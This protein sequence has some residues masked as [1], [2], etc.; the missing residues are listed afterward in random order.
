M[1]FETCFNKSSTIIMEGA[2]GERLKREFN[3]MFDDNVAMAGLIYNADSRQAL[4]SIFQEYLKIAEKYKLPFIATTPTRRANKDRV[5]QSEFTE[6]IIEDNV[7]FLQKIKSNA[8][9]NMFVGGLMGCKGDAYKG[10]DIVSVDEAQEFH[11]WQVKLFKEAG[12]DFL[13]AGIM[14]ELSEAIGM[15]KAMETAE[16]PYIISF[17]IRDDGKLIDGTTINDAILSIDN[18]TIQKPICYMVNCVHPIILKKSLSYSFNK[19]RLVKERFHGIQ[20]NSSPLSPEELDNAIDLKISD[21]VSLANDM[22]DLYN[23]FIPK[24]LGGCCGTDNT[25]MEEIAKRLKGEKDEV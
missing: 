17:M 25:H 15:A 13:F 22:M 20:A 1:N 23:Y 4:H 14:P 21:S 2:L 9:V 12:V 3:I 18:A 10:T 11:L 6:R 8:K 7:R 19:T 5:L 16:L 24:I